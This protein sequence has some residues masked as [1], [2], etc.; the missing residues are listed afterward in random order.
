MEF[1]SEFNKTGMSLLNALERL[2]NQLIALISTGNF[3]IGVKL[4]VGTD[5]KFLSGTK[6]YIDTDETLLIPEEYE[7]DCTELVVDGVVD[8]DGDIN[9]ID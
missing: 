4:K 1:G 5:E 8:C 7:Y 3:N 9:I 2:Y 6:K